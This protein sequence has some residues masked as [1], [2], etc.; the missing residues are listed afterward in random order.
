MTI[1]AGGGEI[2]SEQ[3]VDRWNP[4][5]FRYGALANSGC[6]VLTVAYVPGE[7]GCRPIMKRPASLQAFV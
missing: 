1:L 7:L 4:K 2:A 3:Q 5:L 6:R